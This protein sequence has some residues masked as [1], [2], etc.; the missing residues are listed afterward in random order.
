MCLDLKSD[1]AEIMGK[2]AILNC[3]SAG[4]YCIP[5]LRK[6]VPVFTVDL[7]TI[8]D[9]DRKKELKKLHCVFGHPSA[10]KLID[11]LKDAQ[12]WN[13]DYSAVLDQ[14]VEECETCQRFRKTPSRSKVALPL[15]HS[16][17]DIVCI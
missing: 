8:S 9:K 17:N 11:L 3:T 1:T 2:A 5:I 4:H 7:K 15:S 16:F 12:I 6:E 10:V 13:P 14:I